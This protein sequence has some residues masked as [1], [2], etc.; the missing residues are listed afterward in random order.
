MIGA[1]VA[2]TGTAAGVTAASLLSRR[3]SWALLCWHPAAPAALATAL[4]ASHWLSWLRC[5]LA[6][7]KCPLACLP[8]YPPGAPKFPRPAEIHIFLHQYLRLVAAGEQ[9][10][11][12]K[13]PGLWQLDG[14]TS[15]GNRGWL[16]SEKC[17]A[18]AAKCTIQTETALS[19]AG[20]QFDIAF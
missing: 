1:G 19:S 8:A 4:G 13:C 5:Q 10:E 12:R 15:L 14:R 20:T 18:A 7:L 3:C 17:G 16:G 2:A 6:S 9:E 11:A